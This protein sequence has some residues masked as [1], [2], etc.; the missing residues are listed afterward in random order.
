MREFIAKK[1][2]DDLIDYINKPSNVVAILDGTN[3]TR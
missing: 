3:T 1:V 2:V